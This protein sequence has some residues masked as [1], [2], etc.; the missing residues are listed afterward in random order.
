M[1]SEQNQLTHKAGKQQPAKIVGL[2][3]DTH[4]PVRAKEIPQQ[5]FKIFEKADY[6]I[7]AGDLVQMSVV[8]ELEQLA[9]VLAVHGNMDGP[10]IR[11]RLPRINSLKIF[12][13]KIGV[14]H[15]CGALFGA[16]KMREI[17]ARN[18]FDVLVYGH[19]HSP[20]V[21][22]EA[23]TL[24]VNPGSPTNPTPPFINR[25]TVA[26]LRVT[27]QSIMPEIMPIQK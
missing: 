12:D 18:G 22:T 26:L 25:P 4:V 3:S 21:K 13:W 10:E 9:L 14:I 6:I 23:K 2:I 15:D 24:Y 19:T 8:E 7:H 11:G 16:G 27:T 1:A 17:A 20:A 5:V